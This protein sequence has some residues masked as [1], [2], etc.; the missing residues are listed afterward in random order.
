[1]QDNKDNNPDIE[2]ASVPRHIFVITSAICIIL[3]VCSLILANK[4]TD[5]ITKNN[6]T[7]TYT[8][9]H[10]ECLNTETILTE[11]ITDKTFETKY[12]SEVRDL[13]N[14][15]IITVDEKLNPGDKYTRIAA[16][17][18]NPDY[19]IKIVKLSHM[20]LQNK[21]YNANAVLARSSLKTLCMNE[22]D[23]KTKNITLTDSKRIQLNTLG[24]ISIICSVAIIITYMKRNA[25]EKDLNKKRR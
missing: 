6:V 5:V 4:P 7:I 23:N 17:I 25:D 24:I 19:N 11:N 16:T 1:M 8:D 2:L 20:I 9:R 10:F 13:K 18:E 15:V 3:S 22:M 21:N 12:K 14:N